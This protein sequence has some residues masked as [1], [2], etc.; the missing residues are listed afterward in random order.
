[1]TT[2]T[3]PADPPQC[4]ECGDYIED[5]ERYLDSEVADDDFGIYCLPCEGRNYDEEWADRQREA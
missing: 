4:D 3:L 2:T 1:M 5:A